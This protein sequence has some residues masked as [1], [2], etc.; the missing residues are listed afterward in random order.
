MTQ[1]VFLKL[2]G[3][4][5]TEKDKIATVRPDV[6]S[7]LVSEIRVGREQNADLQILL[8]H[9]SGSFGHVP[10]KKYG[11][12]AG[13]KT[14]EEW[15]GFVEVWQQA[16]ALNNIVMAALA[17]GKVNALAFPPSASVSAQDGAI[18]TWNVAPLRAALQA[19]VIPV[20][21]GD[22]VFDSER[23]GTILSTEDLFA[24]LA[25]EL[26]PAHILLAG[27]E[28][29]V[30]ADHA[31]RTGLIERITPANMPDFAAALGGAAGADVTGGMAGKVAAML[32]MLGHAPDCEISIFSGLEAGNV[33]S[34]L[35]GERLGTT[36]AAH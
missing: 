21:Y 17:A 9:G 18:R 28:A 35:L 33:R 13:V 5:I 14:E 10:A 32:A 3:S 22:V 1:L 12:R 30:Y 15:N 19:S 27:D 16:A 23:G 8:G 29:G 34:A 26:R 11:T 24:H 25:G 36:L 7:R 4:L 2:G 20:V 6:F 31:Q